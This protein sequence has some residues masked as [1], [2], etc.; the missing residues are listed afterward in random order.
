MGREKIKDTDKK[1]RITITIDP[2]IEK[3]LKDSHINL[4]S[5]INDLLKKYINGKKT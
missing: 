2:L 5:L 1:V 3:T 4:S